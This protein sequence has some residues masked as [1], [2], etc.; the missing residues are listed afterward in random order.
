M[1]AIRRPV[2]DHQPVLRVESYRA[3][4]DE[5]EGNDRAVALVIASLHP[6]VVF[7]RNHNLILLVNRHPTRD[8]ELSRQIACCSKRVPN[9][10][11]ITDLNTKVTTIADYNLPVLVDGNPNREHELAGGASTATFRRTVALV[12]ADLNAMVIVVGDVD[13]SRVVDGDASD[14]VELARVS[15]TGAE[16]ADELDLDFRLGEQGHRYEPNRRREEFGEVYSSGVSLHSA[17]DV[18]GQIRAHHD[19]AVVFVNSGG[20]QSAGSVDYRRRRQ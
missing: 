15:A 6:F 19:V 16:P 8:F 20:N 14:R 13:L 3:W 5:A 17:P 18:P 9:T 10:G 2:A 7:I 4:R 1:D 12:I 11:A